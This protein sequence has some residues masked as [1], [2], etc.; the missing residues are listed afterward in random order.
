ML[1]NNIINNI[2]YR[3]NCTI[4]MTPPIVNLFYLLLIHD[5]FD[6]INE[7]KTDDD[8]LKRENKRMVQFKLPHISPLILK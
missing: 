4:L 2:D 6:T 1:L 5:T 3:R 8:L 7:E